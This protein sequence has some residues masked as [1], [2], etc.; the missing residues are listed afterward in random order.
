MR[1]LWLHS[2]WRAVYIH[3][4]LTLVNLE[5]TNF[6]QR[7]SARH[8]AIVWSIPWTSI[9][10]PLG[11]HSNTV[12]QTQHTKHWQLP[13]CHVVQIPEY[14]AEQY[15][16]HDASATNWNP[17]HSEINLD[18][19]G[20][21]VKETQHKHYKL[22]NWPIQLFQIKFIHKVTAFSEVVPCNMYQ[23]QL[24]MR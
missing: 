19:E 23:E 13:V 15:Q 5:R 21:S 18:K 9:W 7:N 16:W 11:Y 17:Q 12:F 20:M 8:V 10:K 14:I 1:K 4:F 2:C 24:I 6:F 3:V 22:C